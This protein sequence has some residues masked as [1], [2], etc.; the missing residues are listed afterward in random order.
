MELGRLEQLG[1]LRPV[2]NI[3]EAIRF[4]LWMYPET[5]GLVATAYSPLISIDYNN[6]VYSPEYAG[7]LHISTKALRMSDFFCPL[8]ALFG[9]D[10]VNQD[11]RLRARSV[12]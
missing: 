1:Q 11:E 2:V 5:R 9:A 7:Y 8:A 3:I 6:P 10:M 4:I 12:R